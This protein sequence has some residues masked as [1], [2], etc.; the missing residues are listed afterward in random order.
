[1]VKKFII[2]LVLK[3]IGKVLVYLYKK[4]DETY[5]NLMEFTNGESF[6][7]KVANLNIFLQILIKDKS[8]RK[9]EVIKT[10]KNDC[11]IEII[12]KNINYA[13]K[14]FTG[15]KSIDQAYI[16]R[17]FILKGDIPKT[18]GLVRA[19]YIV[20][21]LL[22]PKLIWKKIL[23]EKPKTSTKKMNVYLRVIR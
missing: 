10:N 19:L 20:E 3:I 8:T 23:K 22:F 9:M 5:S 1:M 13:F 4:D 14:V 16:E 18:M 12:F 2:S 17:A 11:D 6:K 15:R 21:Y 7:I